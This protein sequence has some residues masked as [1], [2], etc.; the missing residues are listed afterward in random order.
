MFGPLQKDELMLDSYL[1]SVRRWKFQTADGD[2][3]VERDVVR[4]HG[5]ALVLPV[6]DDGRIVLIRNFRYVLGKH[7]W[8]LPCGTLEDGEPP[9]DCAAREL[10]EETGYTAGCIE[11]LGLCHTS[12]GISDEVIHNF[13][14]TD[15]TAGAQSLDAHE[16][17][18]VELLADSRVRQMVAENEITDAKTISALAA[19]WMRSSNR[20]GA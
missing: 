8:E 3:S 15:L 17:I 16:D 10:T 14:A 9:R 18:T 5:A 19:W 11:P 2:G 20:G 7:L 13:L 6:A 12:P 4:T 1:F